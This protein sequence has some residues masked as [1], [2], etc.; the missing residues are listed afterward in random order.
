[1]TSLDRL[2]TWTKWLTWIILGSCVVVLPL[3]V[4]VHQSDHY[5]PHFEFEAWFGFYGV[6]GF[7]ACILLGGLAWLMRTLLERPEDYYDE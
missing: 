7:L 2:A 3:D 6:L 5:H 4:L 1:M